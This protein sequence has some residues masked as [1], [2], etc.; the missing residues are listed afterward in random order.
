MPQLDELNHRIYSIYVDG[1]LKVISIQKILHNE[2]LFI[3]EELSLVEKDVTVIKELWK[4]FAEKLQQSIQTHLYLIKD[5]TESTNYGIYSL[6]VNLERVEFDM[7]MLRYPHRKDSINKTGI[8]KQHEGIVKRIAD[9]SNSFNYIKVE[10][11]L[12][13][14][15][16]FNRI[17]TLWENNEEYEKYAENLKY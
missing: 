6:L 3:I 7:M 10:D 9:I 14:K 11:K 12:I 17:E 13:R 5:V 16:I 2:I 1:V 4:D 15:A 8:K